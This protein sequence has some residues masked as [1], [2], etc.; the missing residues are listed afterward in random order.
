MTAGMRYRNTVLSL[1][2]LQLGSLA[3]CD[4]M[5]SGAPKDDRPD[6]LTFLFKMHGDVSGEQDFRAMTSDAD[7]IAMARDQLL[8]PENERNMFISGPIDRGNGGHN[9]DWNWHFV[10]DQW[11]LTEFAIELCD[12]NAVLVSQDVDYW[13]DTVGQFCP[14]DS[15]VARE[16]P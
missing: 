13:V 5:S 10:P 16:E 7:V 15:Y 9:F 11:T 4:G 6:E 8:L 2:L 3:G 14:W 1:L 12:G